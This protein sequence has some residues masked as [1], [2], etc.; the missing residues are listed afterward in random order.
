MP[1]NTIIPERGYAKD[2]GLSRTPVRMALKRLSQEGWLVW[3]EHKRAVVSE[4]KQKDVYDL[5]TVREMLEPFAIRKT[6]EEK[7]PALLAGMLVPIMTEMEKHKNN[8]YEY[9]KADMFYHYT[10]VNFVGV[11]RLSQ[12]WLKT[13]DEVTRLAMHALNSKHEQSGISAE[14]RNII[15]A[16]WNH[17]LEETL[18]CLDINLRRFLR[19]SYS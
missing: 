5:F 3:E 4:I 13:G 7:E 14:H 10:I 2:L 16:L 12:I 17:D 6:F 8:Y 18:K 9:I 11:E 1:P 19:D 15:D